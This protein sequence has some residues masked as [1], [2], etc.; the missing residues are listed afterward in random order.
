MGIQASEIDAKALATILLSHQHDS[1]A[2]GTLARADSTRLQHFSQMVPNLLSHWWW[3][4]PKLF[5]ER[6]IVNYLYGMLSK[7]S[8]T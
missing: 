8:A 6:G 4:Q 1:I 2:P 5:L 7:V 3:D